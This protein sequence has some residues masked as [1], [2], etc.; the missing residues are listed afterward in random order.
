[1]SRPAEPDSWLG[2][3]DG[4][5]NWLACPPPVTALADIKTPLAEMDEGTPPDESMSKTIVSTFACST[6]PVTNLTVY[7]AVAPGSLGEL[8]TVTLVTIRPC[9]K[10]AP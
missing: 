3:R 2:S 9:C 8:V 7:W 5:T 10:P 1:M 4:V 6:S